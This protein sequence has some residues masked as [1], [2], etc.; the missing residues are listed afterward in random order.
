MRVPARFTVKCLQLVLANVAIFFAYRLLFLAT[1]AERAAWEGTLAVFLRGFR[2]DAALLGTELLVLAVLSLATRHLRLRL[3]LGGLWAFTGLNLLGAVANLLFFHER[4]QH[5]W[6]NLLANASQPR[7]VW[8]AVQPF[9]HL[10][11]LV[12][13]A[14]L[15]TLA[16]GTAL[17]WRSGRALAGQRLDLWRNARARA[18][19]VPV[20]LLLVAVNLE[21]IADQ[22]ERWIGHFRIG[23]TASKHY[24]QFDDYVLN[25]A[26]VNPLFDL[27]SNLPGALGGGRHRYRLDGVQAL[28][29]TETLLGLAP[30]DRRYPL[31]RRVQGAGGLGIR[32]VILLQIEGLGTNVLERQ[33]KDGFL[34]PYL[35][36]LAGQ[37][38]YFPNVY[39]SFCA[40][41][42]ST[43][44]I[45]TSLHRTYAV[46][47]GV[48]RFFP[49]EVNGHYGTLSNVLG[50]SA[51]RHYF[52]A[53]FRQRIADFLSFM[54]NQ[55]YEALGFEQFAARLGDRA[56]QES[57]T[58]G[59]FDGPLLQESA[60]ILVGARGPFTAHIVTSTSHSPWQVPAG[61][62]SPFTGAP[63]AFRYTDDSI[64]SFMERMRREL[65]DFD[66]TLFVLVG[67]H[68]SITFSDSFVE[69][70]RVPLIL[71]GTP[72]V[73]HRDRWTD[74]QGVR[75]SHVDILPTILTLLDG[76][77]PYSGMGTSLL[78]PQTGQAGV[79][80]SNYNTS[81]YLDDSFALRYAP[82][83]G[84]IDV[85]TFA[86]GELIAR[87]VSAA[88]PDVA[89]RLKT[90]YLALFETADRLTR[91]KRVF[92]L[93]ST[94]GRDVVAVR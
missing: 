33:T 50:T 11:P 73:Q 86:D 64:R 4:N 90:E 3:V 7:E 77:H 55:R 69:R 15:L 70:I 36:E 58:L 37:G 45:A 22:K 51:Y 80:S 18:T 25:Q 91:E 31:L 5:L 32:N 82:R 78:G 74:R 81:L 53:G 38:L 43:F 88:H 61:L 87:D 29:E 56:A 13:F 84:A 20:V 9:F 8:V 41:D 39:Q 35:R 21:P 75:A 65:P 19:V 26:V 17:A 48:S 92:P 6:E 23:P 71:Y 28:R 89:R 76:E 62:A 46:S 68:T 10:Y 63:R 44:A 12:P 94:P 47:E 93:D 67:D 72:I 16:A 52:L 49:H 40:T 1:F 14:T 85:M 24:M 30:G 59:I 66:R 54:G 34:T 60:D 2:L 27:L 83:S 57:N 79:I 42:G